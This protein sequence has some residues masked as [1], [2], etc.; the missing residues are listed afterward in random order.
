[1]W[2]R[3][4]HYVG[5]L[6]YNPVVPSLGAG[7]RPNDVNAVAGTSAEVFQYTDFGESSY[8]GL[9]LS[10]QQR[11][12]SGLDLRASYTWSKAEDNSSVFLAHVEDSGRGRNPNDREGLPV[13]F[14]PES[15]HGPA[16][17]DRPHRVVIAATLALPKAIS[18]ATIVAAQSGLPFTPLAGADVNGDGLPLADRARTNPADGTTSVG[19]HRER[20]ASEFTTDVRASRRTA[21]GDHASLDV[22]FEVFNLFNRTNFAQVNDVFGVGAFPTDPQRDASGRVT[23][24][25]YTKALA[26]RQ[27]QLAVRVSF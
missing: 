7:R 19:R 10:W 6:N 11:A 24:G 4:S 9:L 12:S 14:D 17:N 16:P 1:V 20:M 27:A 26:P 3:G 25:R 13:G 22:L 5:A 21:L 2:L 8:R 15:E 23:Y 18:V